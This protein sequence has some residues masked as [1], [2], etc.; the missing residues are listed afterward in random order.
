MNTKTH[1]KTID[2]NFPISGTKIKIPFNMICSVTNKKFTGFVIIE[3][4][5]NKKA[6]EFVDIENFINITSKN[7]LTAEKF[8]HIIFETIKANIRP[9]YLKVLI[10]I[11]KSDAHQPAQVWIEK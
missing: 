10:D 4:C 3:Y 6:V 9:Q 7:K 8:A 1:I 2:I 11:I 5:P